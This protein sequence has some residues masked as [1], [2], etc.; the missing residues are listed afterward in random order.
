MPFQFLCPQGHLLEGVESQMGQQAQCPYCATL[1]IIPVVG[2]GVVPGAAFAPPGMGGPAPAPFGT[3]PAPFGTAPP[4]FPTFPAATAPGSF[5][6]V[7]A[8]ATAEPPG[9][10]EP[11]LAPAGQDGARAEPH[12]PPPPA[13]AE[14]AVEPEPAAAEEE[15]ERVVHIPCPKGHVLET[16][17]SM[18]GMD[19]LCPDCG[20]QFHLRYQDSQEYAQQQRLREERFNRLILRVAVGSAVVIVLG[21]IV[22]FVMAAVR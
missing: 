8:A 19:A 1:F 14:S 12:A 21:V 4:A 18:I 17:M 16:P 10:V 9:M 15:A 7:P 13:V 5:E 20:Q 11:A 3:A 22:L 2:G 6:P